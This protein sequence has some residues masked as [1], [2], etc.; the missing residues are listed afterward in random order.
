MKYIESN[1]PH[2]FHAAARRPWP[3]RR[4]FIVGLAILVLAAAG[5]SDKIEPGT[6]EG[7]RKPSVKAKVVTVN[8]A[9]QPVV[10]EAVG[11]IRAKVSATVSSKLMGVIRAF[12]VAE[13]DAVSAGDV[14]VEL[15]N[16]QVS[17]QLNQTQAALSEAQQGKAAAVSGQRSAEANAERAKLAYRRSRTMLEGGAITQEAFESVDAQYK[18]AQAALAQARSMVDAA[19]DRIKQARAAVDA[20]AVA[21][22]DARV[23]APFN[24]KVTA[25]LADAGEL[26]A[27]GTPL[28]TIERGSGYRVDLVVPEN[29]IDRVRIGQ[30]IS[31][32]IPALDDATIDGS[33]DVIVPSADQGSR[34]FV[35]QVGIGDQTP[36]KSGMFAR[37]PL[38]I[39]EKR[40]IRIPQT[41]VIR[42]GQ[43]TGVFIVDSD[44]T[45][46]F[47]LIRVGRHYGDELEVIS[48]LHD[49]TLLVAAPDVRI[50]NGSPVEYEK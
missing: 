27:P 16:R 18:Q 42:Q 34:T 43:L 36:L 30:P 11:T 32:V 46:R 37:A 3:K 40:M 1:L 29:Y 45:A 21:S 35:V 48:G 23:M 6:A 22:K 19:S 15:D 13:G 7:V 17:A 2:R 26:A 50:S 8:E 14:L 4:Q 28:L 9:L 47:R 10:Y 31:V 12:R 49:S 41:A 44:Q 5:C 39:G 38:A 33:V 25:K 24:G 20:A